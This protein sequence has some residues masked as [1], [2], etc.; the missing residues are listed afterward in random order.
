[1][2]ADRNLTNNVAYLKRR[3]DEDLDGEI[4]ETDPA[5]DDDRVQPQKVKYRD[6]ATGDMWSGRGRIARWLK[7]KQLAGEDIE[8]YRV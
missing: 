8:K 4:A 1:M 2:G 6:P 3:V 7:A 5:T